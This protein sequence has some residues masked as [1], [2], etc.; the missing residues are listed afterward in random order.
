MG[1]PDIGMRGADLPHLI[2]WPY[3]IRIAPYWAGRWFWRSLAIGRI[4]LPEE[5]RVQMLMKEG[6]KAP[7]SDRDIYRDVD[8]LKLC[9]R[10]NGEAFAQGYDHVWDDGRIGCSDFGFKVQDIR[11]DLKVQLWYGKYDYFVPLNHGLQIAAR[12]NGRAHLRVEDEAHAGILMH[13]KR[14][15]LEGLRNSM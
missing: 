13:W 6:E 7:E 10:A 2:G 9:V 4:D 1:P 11:K 8:F 14:E 3:G 5:Q 15:I 12:L